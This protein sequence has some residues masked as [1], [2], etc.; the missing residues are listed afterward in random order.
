MFELLLYIF[1][2]I[3]EIIESLSVNLLKIFQ[4]KHNRLCFFDENLKETTCSHSLDSLFP[5]IK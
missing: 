3:T 4:L 1:C 5:F 2:L